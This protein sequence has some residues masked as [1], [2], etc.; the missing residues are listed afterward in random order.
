MTTAIEP[1]LQDSQYYLSSF[2]IDCQERGLTV[3]SISSYKSH[4]RHF[5]AAFPDAPPRDWPVI[6]KWLKRLRK[7]DAIN[8]VRKS[9]QAFYA[10][11]ERSEWGLSPIPKGQRGRPSKSRSMTNG[12]SG[13]NDAQKIARVGAVSPL[14]IELH[15]YLHGPG[16]SG[17][18][19]RDE[20]QS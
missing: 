10:F 16:L 19:K 17:L 3:S 6:E 5:V 15:V 13:V 12:L 1:E 9:L 18:L 4:L 7:K 8:R 14:R 20:I 2:L 11:L